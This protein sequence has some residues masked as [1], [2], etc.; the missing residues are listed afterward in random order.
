MLR[1]GRNCNSAMLQLQLLLQ[2]MVYELSRR[3]SGEGHTMPNL[4][5]GPHMDR[6]QF[7]PQRPFRSDT[8]IPSCS[9]V[10][11]SESGGLAPSG[12]GR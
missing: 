1:R 4:R 10:L 12:S 8:V 11:S 7:G 9:G 5:G 3:F 6:M 2:E